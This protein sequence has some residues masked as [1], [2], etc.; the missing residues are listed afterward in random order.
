[1]ASLHV[2][3]ERKALEDNFAKI[4]QTLAVLLLACLASRG[5]V[6]MNALWGKVCSRKRL[7]AV[8]STQRLQI[9]H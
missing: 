3:A 8:R 5:W 9:R 7:Q 1:M 6:F 4:W 2:L